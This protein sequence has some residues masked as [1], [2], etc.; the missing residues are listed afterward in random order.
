M[1]ARA[2]AMASRSLD[3]ACSVASDIDSIDFV[4]GV[5]DA[6]MGLLQALQAFKALCRQNCITPHLLTIVSLVS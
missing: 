3:A 4:F 2:M 6:I 5:N 1:M